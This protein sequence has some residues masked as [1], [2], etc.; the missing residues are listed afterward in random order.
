MSE[1]PESTDPDRAERQ[2]WQL[3]KEHRKVDAMERM[4][5]HADTFALVPAKPLPSKAMPSFFWTWKLK[6]EPVPPRARSRSRAPPS[7]A[8]PCFPRTQPMLRSPPSARPI[9][10]TSP[11]VSGRDPNARVPLSSHP[12]SRLRSPSNRRAE[13]RLSTSGPVASEQLRTARAGTHC[14]R[15]LR[16]KMP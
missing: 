2:H 4:Q 6:T 10:G 16:S 12:S 13:R 11:A 8:M 5:R 9:P 7:K 1:K 15:I 3:G 14:T